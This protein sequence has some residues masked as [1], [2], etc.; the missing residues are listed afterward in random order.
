MHIRLSG[1]TYT[2]LVTLGAL[3]SLVFLAL[4]SILGYY[5]P[6]PGGDDTQF[7]ISVASGHREASN[8][9]SYIVSLFHVDTSS[10]FQR[11][12]SVLGIFK[13]LVNPIL[14]V[15]LIQQQILPLKITHYGKTGLAYIL[16]YPTSYFIIGGLYRDPIICT[17]YLL[18]FLSLCMSSISAHKSITLRT[19]SCAFVLILAYISSIV[20]RPQVLYILFITALYFIGFGIFKRHLKPKP[21]LILA[22]ISTLIGVSILATV[23]NE[24]LISHITSFEGTG[25]RSFLVTLINVPL[26]GGP[27]YLIANLLYSFLGLNPSNP[28]YIPI[29]LFETIPAILAFRYLCSSPSQVLR[30]PINLFLFSFILANILVVS[31]SCP[32]TGSSLRYRFPIFITIVPFALMLHQQRHILRGRSHV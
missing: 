20:L 15:I 26:I 6:L 24:F 16:L 21:L 3:L 18:I 32:N 29:F 22:A 27:L 10:G 23:Y 12:L 9:W 7:W 25:E 31:L 1:K 11:L 5:P 4:I 2:F 19:L 28:A 30:N 8:M 13:Y 17:L 14:L